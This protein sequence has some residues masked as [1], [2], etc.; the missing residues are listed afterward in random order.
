[1]MQPYGYRPPQRP[2]GYYNNNQARAYNVPNVKESVR[3]T[4]ERKRSNKVRAFALWTLVL[5]VVA[6]MIMALAE[7]GPKSSAIDIIKGMVRLVA[8]Q[9]TGSITS[10][11]YENHALRQVGRPADAWFM[12]IGAT[13]GALAFVA[14][15]LRSILRLITGK[16]HT[17]ALA[18]SGLIFVGAL[19]MIVGSA[20]VYGFT[21][22][23][24]LEIALIVVFVL[25]L[26][27]IISAV[28]SPKDRFVK[29]TKK[30][31]RY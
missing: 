10:Y 6:L 8:P 4:E 14:L 19:L 30:Y 12:P 29:K 7:L 21:S 20:L 26:I 31:G 11:Y 25:A 5:S 17:K 15:L 2:G 1:M 9:Q 23:Q 28:F 24:S 3:E 27:T 13:L 16:A 22:I 18:V